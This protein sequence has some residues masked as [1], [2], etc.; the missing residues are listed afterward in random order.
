MRDRA[1][2]ALIAAVLLST[3]WAGNALAAEHG[4][5][6]EARAMAE[7]A[8][9]HIRAVGL[10]QAMRDFND[11]RMPFIDRD[12]WVV[13]FR[14]ADGQVLSNHGVPATLGKDAR[15]LRDADGKPFGQAILDQAAS[16]QVGWVI[17]RLANPATGR[18]QQKSSFVVGVEQHALFVGAYIY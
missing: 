14:T 9:S 12:L 6:P 2:R 16:G 18:E 13:V 5:E 7:A 11:P 17:Y 10:E 1:R 15:L 8:A 3:A 4:T